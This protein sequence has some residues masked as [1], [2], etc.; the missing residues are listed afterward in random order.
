MIEFGPQ[1]RGRSV[2]VFGQSGDSESPH[3]FDQAPLYSERRFKPAWFTRE[4][5]EANATRSYRPEAPPAP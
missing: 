3:F 2:L 4:E 5:V 1:A